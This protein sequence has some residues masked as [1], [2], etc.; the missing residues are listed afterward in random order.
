MLNST[1]ALNLSYQKMGKIGKSN[2]NQFGTNHIN[3]L[4]PW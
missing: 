2:L 3:T 1:S 4:L